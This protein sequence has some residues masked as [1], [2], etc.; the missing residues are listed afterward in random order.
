M[1]IQTTIEKKIQ[2]ELK[3]THLE[4]INESPRHHVPDGAESHFKVV[5]A[6][7]NFA[8]LSLVKRHQ[9]IYQLLADELKDHIHALTMHTY[10]PEEWEAEGGAPESPACRGGIHHE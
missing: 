2:A 3:P 1:I 4:V 10:T 6:S 5:V 9:V 7:K 8:G